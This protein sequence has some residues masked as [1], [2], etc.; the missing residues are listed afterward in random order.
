[1]N[2][3]EDGQL[4]RAIAEGLAQIERLIERLDQRV[5]LL[6]ADQRQANERLVRLRLF[7]ENKLPS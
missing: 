2:R 1:M 7:L 4:M 5:E 3:S 6:Q